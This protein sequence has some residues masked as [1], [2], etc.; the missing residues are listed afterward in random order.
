MGYV[1]TP[2]KRA[3]KRLQYAKHRDQILAK[4]KKTYPKRKVALTNWRRAHPIK[5]LESRYKIKI[6]RAAPNHCEACKREFADSDG[7]RRCLDH[8]HEAGEFRGWLC[9]SCNMA[10]GI[11]DDSKDRIA[12]LLVYLHL[13][14][15]L[16]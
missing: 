11:L 2:E 13:V 3:Y 5:H 16:K 15:L 8:D 1:S 7:L 12:G 6:T 9:K 14:E 4:A 10:L